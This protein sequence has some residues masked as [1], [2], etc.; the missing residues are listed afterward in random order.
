MPH[1]PWTGPDGPDRGDAAE[2]HATPVTDPVASLAGWVADLQASVRR[3]RRRRRAIAASSAAGV[4]LLTTVG[5]ALATDQP[6][7]Q[8]PQMALPSPSSLPVDDPWL[9]RPEAGA[10]VT[11]VTPAEEPGGL[12]VSAH[13]VSDVAR[14]G[15]PISV[16]VTW[17]D[18]DGRLV[19][20]SRE[21]GDGTRASAPRSHECEETTGVS[22]DSTWYRHT[23]TRPGQYLVRFAV[24]T[25]TCDGRTE[26]R[27]VSFPVR[28][29]APQHRPATPAKTTNPAPVPTKSTAPSPTPTPGPTQSS[30][31]PDESPTKTPSE[32][33]SSP[34]S[35]P[36]TPSPPSSAS[37]APSG[38][39]VPS[40][41]AREQV[42]AG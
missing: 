33:P 23:Y 3:S 24:T 17:R 12:T 18:E 26:K 28:V 1:P 20:L 5:V 9:T 35:S 30:P 11:K 21:W 42:L 34:S 4:L 7:P 22:G 39:T 38:S 29:I 19:D 31:V 13:T 15:R 2:P 32:P 37:I 25:A 27:F 40:A 10:P 8:I 6:R 14:V 41:T 16:E 36:A